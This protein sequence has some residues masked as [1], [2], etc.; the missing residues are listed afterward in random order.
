MFQTFFLQNCLII[1]SDRSFRG[2]LFCDECVGGWW[3]QRNC[4]NLFSTYVLQNYWLN[5]FD[6]NFYRL[7]LIEWFP[8]MIHAI[9]SM[10]VETCLCETTWTAIAFGWSVVQNPILANVKKM[11]WDACLMS[12]QYSI[13]NQSWTK[14][15]HHTR[16][17][18]YTRYSKIVLFDCALWVMKNFGR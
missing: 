8:F 11:F 1:L 15:K 13:S 16:T 12:I 4:A 3:N 2:Q 5:F 14:K 18:V 9:L 6:N 7:L 10:A 17:N